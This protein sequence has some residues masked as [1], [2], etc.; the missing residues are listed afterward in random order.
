[1]TTIGNDHIKQHEQDVQYYQLQ[2]LGSD[3]RISVDFKKVF[4]FYYIRYYNLPA[5]NNT[6]I[7]FEDSNVLLVMIY[8]SSL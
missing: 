8:I 5:C 6:N 3:L 4:I 7:F 1:M 2:Y